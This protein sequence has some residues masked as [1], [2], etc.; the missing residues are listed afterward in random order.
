MSHMTDI[1]LTESP[2][3]Y[4][5]LSSSHIEEYLGDYDYYTEKKT[6]QLE[7][8]KMNQQE[9]TDKTPATVKS[10]SKRSYEEEKEWKKKERQ[11]LRRI[12]EIETTVQTIE[13]NISRND[14]L[15]CD[16]EVYQDHEKVQAIH[17][18]NEKLNQEPGIS[19]V[20]MG[21]TIHRR[22]LKKS[23]TSF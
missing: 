18:D 7:L 6:E 1:L 22:R 10:D 16:P 4:W 21:R 20:R 17:A 12:E 13:E 2:Q 5:S 11:R 23:S 3:E 15:L 8:E 19:F 14:E 9:E